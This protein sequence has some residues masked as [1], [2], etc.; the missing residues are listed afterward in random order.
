MSVVLEEYAELIDYNF[1]LIKEEL[2]QQYPSEHDQYMRV[3]TTTRAFEKRDYLSGLGIPMKNRDTQALPWDQPVKG[4]ASTF[5]PVTY[6]LGY[7]IDRESVEDEQWGLLASRP[8]SMVYG[9]I[10][11][12]DMVAADILNNGLVLQS[13]DLGGTSL[14]STANTREDGGAP[15]ANLIAEIQPIAVETVFN[16]VVS[17]L[18]LLNDSR[19]LAINFGNSLNL[20][21]PMINPELWEQALAVVNSMMNPN[22]TDNRINSLTKQFKLN[23]V[24]LRYATNPN[25]WFIGWAPSM[26]NYGLVLFNRV[27]PTI[28]PLKPF[29]DNED[30]WWSRL[31]MRFTAGYENKR[32][33]AAVGQ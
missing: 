26:S 20:Y 23:L 19:G 14:F 29:G 31:R 1:G 2:Y 27:E 15:W 32:G 24:P 9:S 6:R 28:S 5:I 4:F 30:V 16:A 10:V 11:I 8:K 18:T 22:T 21:I 17:L 25:L 12:K 3:E 13:Y 7:Q 33:I